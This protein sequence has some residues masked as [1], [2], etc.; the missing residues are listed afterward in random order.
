MRLRKAR[1]ALYTAA[2]AMVTTTST[3]PAKT[4]QS[5]RRTESVQQRPML[6]TTYN[7][8]VTPSEG[9]RGR[10]EN[11]RLSINKGNK[12]RQ[13]GIRTE[14]TPPGVGVCEISRGRRRGS[15]GC[16]DSPLH[17]R[18]NHTRIAA[19]PGIRGLDGHLLR[20]HR[21]AGRGDRSPPAE[22]PVLS[23]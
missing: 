18:G 13:N 5:Q 21:L 11:D 10:H 6:I 19:S 7:A 8:I 23:C 1:L 20:T 12:R 14:A 4:S 15:W 9:H 16:K 17:I 22:F 2:A 3:M